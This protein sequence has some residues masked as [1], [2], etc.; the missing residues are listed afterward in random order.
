MKRYTKNE[1]YL[2][3]A[4]FAAY[5]S[6]YISRCNLSP[7]LN[8]I[9][10]TFGISAAQAGLIP[11]CFAI[12]YAA[13]QIVSG[14]LADR[15]PAPRLMLIGLL[16]SSLVNIIFSVSV[17]FPLLVA[18]WFVNGLLQSMIWTPIM[19]I[20][21]SQ[22]RE[23][24]RDHAAFFM[25]LTL[26]FGYLLAWALSGLLTSLLSW[27]VAFLVSGLVTA[28]IAVPSV[29]VIRNTS[30][31][32]QAQ[33]K[34]QPQERAPVWKLLLG[35]N[36]VL[37]LICCVANGYVRDS[38]TYWATK[39]L[40]DTQGI[41]LNSAVGIILIIPC[42]NF[43]GIQ[44]GKSAYK[45]TG[46]NVFISSGILFAVCTVLC[47]LIG[48]V[49]GQ[50]FLGCIAVL[51]LIS[52]MA[53]GLNPLLTTLMPMLY[54]NLNRVALAAGLLDAMIYVGSAFS[55]FFAGY[56]SDRFG[57]DGVFLSWAVVSLI[58][59]LLLEIARR[60]AKR[61]TEKT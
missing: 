37:L 18:L 1:L 3:I 36:L 38:I 17:S 21:V 14:L 54:I 15:Y 56:L 52:A 20:I 16:G 53:Y 19:R 50:S 24:V 49:A 22:F 39:L 51:V 45:R 59:T 33:N 32:I 60:M 35:T 10:E 23:N 61:G 34:E 5:T 2:L 31:D 41:D 46:N 13:G 6:A 55:G 12:P 9:A 43:M 58:G 28:G 7:S 48:P 42:V 25:S 44:M 47:A 40:M 8:A 57:W 11:T 27:R 4:C 29:L 30:A 26:I